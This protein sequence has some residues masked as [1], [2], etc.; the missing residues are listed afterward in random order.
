MEVEKLCVI[1]KCFFQLYNNLCRL[2]T[3]FLV[4]YSI[5]E[6]IKDNDVSRVDY[7][8]FHSTTSV[9]YPSISLCFGDVLSK[10]KLL[11]YGIDP[12][13]YKKFLK[14]EFWNETY[15]DIKYEDLT[16]DMNDYLL[17]IEIYEEKSNGDQDLN[18]YY[19]FSWSKQT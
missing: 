7:A 5:F 15:L 2:L 14:G 10:D 11:K 8:P 18:N 16:K 3:L 13:L 4:S 6:Y 17:A 12:T 1:Y 9:I 19:L